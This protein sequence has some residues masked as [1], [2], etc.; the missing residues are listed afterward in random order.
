LLLRAFKP[1]FEY[2]SE[3]LK[4]IIYLQLT[5]PLDDNLVFLLEFQNI[6]IVLNVYLMD[7]GSF[8]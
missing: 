4:N 5:L 8:L 1:L 6:S 2:A 3:H 7:K